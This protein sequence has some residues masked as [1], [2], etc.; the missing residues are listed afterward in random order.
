MHHVRQ[1]CEKRISQYKVRMV[2]V[3]EDMQKEMDKQNELLR[4]SRK[5]CNDLRDEA[6]DAQRGAITMLDEQ[7]RYESHIQ[8][9]QSDVYRANNAMDKMR[10]EAVRLRSK[11]YDLRDERSRMKQQQRLHN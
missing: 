5:E 1:E 9:L 8:R 3:Q 2:Q 11:N 10:D 4:R 7:K 6:N